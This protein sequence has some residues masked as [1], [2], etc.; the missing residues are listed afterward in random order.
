VKSDNDANPHG[1]PSTL[2]VMSL[3]YPC[4]LHTIVSLLSCGVPSPHC[5]P[6]C[7]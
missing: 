7:V 6:L 3:S 2:E 4:A 1:T 5:Q